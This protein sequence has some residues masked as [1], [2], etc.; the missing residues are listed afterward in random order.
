MWYTIKASYALYF[1]HFDYTYNKLYG[2]KQVETAEAI[3]KS[4]FS[5]CRN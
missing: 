3:I 2:I 1:P 5:F 4:P